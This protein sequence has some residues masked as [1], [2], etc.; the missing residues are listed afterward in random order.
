M[1]AQPNI[2]NAKAYRLACELAALTG[3]SLTA[4]V[5]A[6]LRERVERERRARIEALAAAI[7]AGIRGPVSSADHNGLYGPDGLPA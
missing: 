7:R 5:T 1:G 6:A 3:E 4:A 2:K